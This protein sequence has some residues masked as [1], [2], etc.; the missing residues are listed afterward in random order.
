MTSAARSAGV[1]RPAKRARTAIACHDAANGALRWRQEV[2]DSPE[3]DEHPAPR[4][5][6]HLLTLAG[7]QVV[8]CS[9][10]GAIVALDALTGK[11]TWGVRYPDRGLKLAE[12]DAPGREP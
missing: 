4:P 9:H 12:A 8:Y 7:T 6:Q 3:Y 10:A 1:W 11:R 2:C 5:R